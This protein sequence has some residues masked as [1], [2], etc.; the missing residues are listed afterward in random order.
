MDETLLFEFYTFNGQIHVTQGAVLTYFEFE[1]VNNNKKLQ[2]SGRIPPI[3]SA[4]NW[5]RPCYSNSTPL[6][7][8]V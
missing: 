5:M 7:C 1:N 6:N 4:Q 8:V 2:L 3:R